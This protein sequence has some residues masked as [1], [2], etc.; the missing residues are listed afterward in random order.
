MQIICII[1]IWVLHRPCGKLL[2]SPLVLM[3]PRAATLKCSLNHAECSLNH[4]ECSL[5]HAECSLNHAECSLNHAECSL[6]HASADVLVLS[7]PSFAH[8]NTLLLYGALFASASSSALLMKLWGGTPSS[9]AAT[10]ML[11]RS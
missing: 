7:A 10:L 8:R 11:V 6:N 9:G 2:V 3:R 1:S 5:N 4:A